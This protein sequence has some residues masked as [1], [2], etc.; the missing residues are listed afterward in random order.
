ME[1]TGLHGKL[2]DYITKNERITS[3][4]L[5]YTMNDHTESHSELKDCANYIVNLDITLNHM[6]N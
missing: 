2:M 1:Y 5:N 6:I 4:T 3:Y